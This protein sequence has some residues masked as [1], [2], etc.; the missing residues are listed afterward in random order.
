M[1]LILILQVGFFLP[2][3]M[4][5]PITY[6][7]AKHGKNTLF[8]PLPPPPVALPTLKSLILAMHP[9]PPVTD[10][11]H[12]RI[13]L[14]GEPVET[15]ARLGLN[16]WVRSTI[17]GYT[18]YVNGAWEDWAVEEP[19]SSDDEGEEDGQGAGDGAGSN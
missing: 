14:D 8:L 5:D 12:V 15:E 13:L 10:P 4:T 1:K 2:T 18:F 9:E 3:S 11:S 17:L 16:Q 7:R 6:V 19:L